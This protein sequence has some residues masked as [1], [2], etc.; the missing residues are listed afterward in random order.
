VVRIH[1]AGRR[2]GHCARGLAIVG[3]APSSRC[4][5]DRGAATGIRRAGAA[6]RRVDACGADRRAACGSAHACGAVH[7]PDAVTE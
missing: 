6:T 3:I 5:P 4:R 2:N 7:A 1:S